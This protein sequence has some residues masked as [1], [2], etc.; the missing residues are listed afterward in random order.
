MKGRD[1]NGHVAPGS[2]ER[3][4]HQRTDTSANENSNREI[5]DEFSLSWLVVFCLLSPYLTINPGKRYEEVDG[6]R[7]EKERLTTDSP[8]LLFSFRIPLFH[9]LVLVFILPSH[10]SSTNPKFREMPLEVEEECKR[11]RLRLYFLRYLRLAKNNT[12]R[13]MK[14]KGK[15][16]YWPLGFFFSHSS[17]GENPKGKKEIWELRPS[18]LQTVGPKDQ[19]RR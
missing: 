5:K 9:L 7:K 2:T 16:N 12:K 18:R 17:V 15:Y 19:R 14:A 13:A 3:R 10:S 6:V 4:A 1:S 11:S 8:F